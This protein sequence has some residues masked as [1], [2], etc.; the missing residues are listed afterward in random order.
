M[1]IHIYI[2]FFKWE[3][4][5]IRVLLFMVPLMPRDERVSGLDGL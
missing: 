4:L 3:W 5:H 1:R 2:F